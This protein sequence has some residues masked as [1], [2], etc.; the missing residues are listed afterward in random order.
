MNRSRGQLHPELFSGQV[1]NEIRSRYD[2]TRQELA[3]LRLL[4]RGAMNNV[5]GKR[6]R[7]KQSTVRTH[8]RSVYEKTH[9]HERVDVI[10][11]FVHLS[12]KG[13]A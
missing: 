5:I 13:S 2:L 3:V 12:R 8:L 4:C 10:L 9:C 6:L 7:I 11:T 1:W